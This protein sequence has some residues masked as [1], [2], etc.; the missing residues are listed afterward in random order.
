MMWRRACRYSPIAE[1]RIGDIYLM[2]ELFNSPIA[3]ARV[4]WQGDVDIG[5]PAAT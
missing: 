4:P 2:M 5:E 1:R 3:F